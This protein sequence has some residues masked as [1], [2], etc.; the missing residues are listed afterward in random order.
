MDGIVL[1]P[2]KEDSSAASGKTTSFI[3]LI[4]AGHYDV[5]RHPIPGSLVQP[6]IVLVTENTLRRRS[7]GCHVIVVLIAHS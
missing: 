7:H 1:G 2:C 6:A 4:P 5:T 3:P